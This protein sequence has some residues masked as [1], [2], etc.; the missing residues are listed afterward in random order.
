MSFPAVSSLS[1]KIVF[2]LS[3]SLFLVMF[4]YHCH[5]HHN[6]YSDAWETP[7]Y[8]FFASY[9]DQNFFQCIV[10]YGISFIDIHIV[11]HISCKT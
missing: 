6:W 1:A 2:S 9:L 8:W 4:T 5:R 7:N 3:L 10:M 11:I